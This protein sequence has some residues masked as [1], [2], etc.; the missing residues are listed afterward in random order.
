MNL[1]WYAFMVNDESSSWEVGTYSPDFAYHW[2]DTHPDGHI[3]VINNNH[4]SVCKARIYDADEII[5]TDY[6]VIKDATDEELLLMADSEETW[7]DFSCGCLDEYAYRNDIDTSD[8]ADPDE[9][10]TKLKAFEEEK[11]A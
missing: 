6:E 3:E 2:L 1:E 11:K 4:N 5:S 9:T 10:F 7:F 8:C